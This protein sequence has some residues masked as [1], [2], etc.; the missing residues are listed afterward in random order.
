MASPAYELA[1]DADGN[2][3]LVPATTQP[4][5]PK[6]FFEDVASKAK[7]YFAPRVSDLTEGTAAA[8]EAGKDISRR[9]YENIRANPLYGAGQVVAGS[10]L[11]AI[12]PLAGAT[13]FVVRPVGRTF[14]PSAERAADIATM[15]A[16]TPSK[17]ASMF[18]PRARAATAA[19]ELSNI[20]REFSYLPRDMQETI[21][22]MP[23]ADREMVFRVLREE[24]QAPAAAAARPAATSATEEAVQTAR[25]I[26]PVDLAIQQNRY[27]GRFVNPQ[28]GMAQSVRDPL[29]GRSMA[30]MG[31]VHDPF[32]A[33][34]LRAR[35]L[36]AEARSYLTEPRPVINPETGYQLQEIGPKGQFGQLRT[37]WTPGQRVARTG[38]A[39]APLVAAGALAPSPEAPYSALSNTDN[40]WTPRE[41]IGAKNA[42]ESRV[43]DANYNPA[44]ADGSIS[45]EQYGERA[46][47]LAAKAL[48]EAAGLPMRRPVAT[49]S[50][51]SRQAAAQAVADRAPAPMR[52]PEEGILSKIFSG[53]D[54]QSKGGQLRQDGRINWGDPESAADF[55]RADRARRETPDAP[56][57]KR[58]GAVGKPD[59][60]HKALEIIHHLL[61][62]G[63]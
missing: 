30:A 5:R 6:G 46:N 47:M 12:S 17:G 43:R 14:G 52:R 29:T 45:G 59:S 2:V 3:V 58:G 18:R 34:A 9:G 20:P 35:E 19:S 31:A 27:P 28:T 7:E 21:N 10:A 63:H 13:E 55:F 32:E 40:S 50:L 61:M 60:V 44:M 22:A 23:P 15:V 38:V 53:Q 42:I 16:P 48:G 62:R 51:E 33:L 39:A 37:E 1:R 49:P 25:A 26:S 36:P 56:G 41:F 11:S 54:Y 8:Y 4:Q 24:A 57:M